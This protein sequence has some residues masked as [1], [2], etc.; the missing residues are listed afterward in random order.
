M[1]NKDIEQDDDIRIIKHKRTSDFTVIYNSCINDSNLSA[2][3]LA[4]LVYIMSKP[5]DWD[6]RIVNLCNRFKIGRDKTYN[7]I[8]KLIKLGYMKR[9]RDRNNDGSLGKTSIY[10]SDNPIFLDDPHT[11]IQD[12]VESETTDKQPHPEKPDM[13]N[14]DVVPYIQK[15]EINKENNN[16]KILSNTIA[17]PKEIR[18][19]IVRYQTYT[20]MLLLLFFL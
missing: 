18:Q 12:M 13:V 6:V 1:L 16:N 9:T 7:V 14:Q 4:I 10:T 19:F 15:K 17:I 3:C 2:E 5:N 11:E 20:Q 8:N